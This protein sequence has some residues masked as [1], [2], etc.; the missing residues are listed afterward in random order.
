MNSYGYLPGRRF[1]FSVVRASSDDLAAAAAAGFFLVGDTFRRLELAVAAAFVD[2]V[3]AVVAAAVVRMV[4]SS[5]LDDR[6]RR[7]H[8]LSLDKLLS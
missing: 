5:S 4:S 3:D 2:G 7:S 1:F 8:S 6:S